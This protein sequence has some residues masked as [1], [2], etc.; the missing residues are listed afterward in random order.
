MTNIYTGT[1]DPRGFE[2]VFS[3]DGVHPSDTG[4]AVVGNVLLSKM[5]QVLG[6][7]PR[8]AHI[9]AARPIDEKAVFAA[10][11]HRAGR[12]RA[13]ITLDHQSVEALR[14]GSKY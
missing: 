2:G 4:H 13:A 7:N 9:A 8:F 1:R 14:Q 10:D 5:Q 6:S 12:A 11:P 3:F